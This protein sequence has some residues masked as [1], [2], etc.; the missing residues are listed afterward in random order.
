MKKNP[1][2]SSAVCRQ[3]HRV[4]RE[5]LPRRPLPRAMGYCS[6]AGP[7]LLPCCHPQKHPYLL[8][9]PWKRCLCIRSGDGL[10]RRCATIQTTSIHRKTHPVYRYLKGTPVVSTANRLGQD[11][12]EQ[13][14]KIPRL[15]SQ[16]PPLPRYLGL[17]KTFSHLAM[18]SGA[19][20]GTS[21]AS[22]SV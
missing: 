8:F 13:N 5:C 7:A 21:T 16:L 6:G 2:K 9:S 11:T 17:V 1:L 20:Q 19:T 10:S 14:R 3:Q 4:Q 18:H 22:A 15:V 12:M